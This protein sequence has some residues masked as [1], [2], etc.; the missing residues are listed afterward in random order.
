MSLNTPETRRALHGLLLRLPIVGGLIRR[1]EGGRFARLFSTLIGAGLPAASALD[2]AKGGATNMA[3]AEALQDV[4]SALVEG[5]GI[6]EP[7]ATANIFPAVL[8]DLARVGEESG[9]LGEVL[10]HAANILEEEAENEIQRGI[11]LLA[12]LLTIG[13]GGVIAFV[14]ASVVMAILSMN[15]IAM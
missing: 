14:I 2:L 5:R 7:L 12:P 6:A 10:G 8:L 13:L 9:R 11:A 3:F 1:I 4:R 15:S